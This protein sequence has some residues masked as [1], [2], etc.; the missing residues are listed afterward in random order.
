MVVS[1]KTP[2]TDLKEILEGIQIEG[3]MYTKGTDHA[4]KG[5]ISQYVSILVHSG[6]LNPSVRGNFEDFLLGLVQI[7]TT[8]NN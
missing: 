5:T 1:N 4:I 3:T 7:E 6:F 8:G 2:F